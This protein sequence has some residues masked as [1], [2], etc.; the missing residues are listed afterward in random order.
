MMDKV[1]QILEKIGSLVHARLIVASMR[2]I[3]IAT[4]IVVIAFAIL[5]VL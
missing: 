3:G 4:A 2:N 5:A 1:N